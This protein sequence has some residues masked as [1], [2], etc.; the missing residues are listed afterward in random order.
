MLLE[1][2]LNIV[3]RISFAF[4]QFLSQQT[5]KNDAKKGKRR[6][7]KTSKIEISK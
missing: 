4:A 6:R 3:E 1:R 7:D 2:A 5:Q